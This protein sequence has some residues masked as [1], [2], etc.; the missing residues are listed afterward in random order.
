MLLGLRLIDGATDARGD[1]RVG[2]LGG[3]EVDIL[4]RLAPRHAAG[5]A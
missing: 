3:R 5:A 1:V 2:A 4:A